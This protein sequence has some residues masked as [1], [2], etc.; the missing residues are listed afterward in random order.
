MSV[1]LAGWLVGWIV[2]LLAGWMVGWPLPRGWGPPKR[3]LY[4]AR[5][6]G[7]LLLLILLL[8]L[9]VGTVDVV[10]RQENGPG[11]VGT[12]ALP[13]ISSIDCSWRNHHSPSVTIE[14]Y[15][16]QP[17]PAEKKTVI[18]R[19]TLCGQ[20]QTCDVS[21]LPTIV[22]C[23]KAKFPELQI[24]ARN[25]DDTARLKQSVGQTVRYLKYPA[26]SLS[27]PGRSRRTSRSIIFIPV[28]PLSPPHSFSS[29][30]SS[31]APTASSTR[32][33]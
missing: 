1:G 19:H 23:P 10:V 2:G 24:P 14:P 30:L 8:L 15:P 12:G 9:R 29:P 27:R 32:P 17:T 22:N 33:R 20:R 13:S 28:A 6:G 3:G 16:I 31:S 21:S 18:R 4:G 26:R 7:R 25:D 11:V 5:R